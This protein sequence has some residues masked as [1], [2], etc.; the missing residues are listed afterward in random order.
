[1]E[2]EHQTSITQAWQA[3][4]QINGVISKLQPDRLPGNFDVRYAWVQLLSH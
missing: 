2:V 1:M 3:S 4:M